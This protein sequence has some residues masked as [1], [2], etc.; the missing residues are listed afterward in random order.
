MVPATPS[1]SFPPP[2]PHPPYEH[3]RDGA[4]RPPQTLSSDWDPVPPRSRAGLIVR[5]LCTVLYFPL[6]VLLI[7]ALAVA[8]FAFGL[9]AELL[10]FFDKP[11]ERALDR[12]LD[13]FPFRPRWW[14]TWSELRHE[15]AGDP[16]FYR[17]RIGE[18]L[19]RKKPTDS[20]AFFRFHAYRGIGARGLLDLAAEHGWQ[21]D[22]DKKLRPLRQVDLTRKARQDTT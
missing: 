20:K 6:H 18:R 21:L 2:P 13:P 1:P 7:I 5:H 11:M 9:V 8:V 10:I 19:G 3:P 22:P 16:E 12:A 17:A 15:R 4:A 14:A